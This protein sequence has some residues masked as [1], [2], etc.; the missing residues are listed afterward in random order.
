M[1][2][3]LKKTVT[4]RCCEPHNHRGKRLVVSLEPGDVICFREERSRH[5]FSA[6]LSKVYHQ[7]VR[8]NIES[9]TT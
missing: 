6:P 4:R 2:T 5:Y 1:T 8:W 9:I 7:I 3:E